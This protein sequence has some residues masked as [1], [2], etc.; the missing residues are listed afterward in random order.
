METTRA[1]I[2]L[3]AIEITFKIDAEDSGGSHTVFECRVAPAGKVP[4]PHSHDGFEETIYGLDGTST[5]TVD[6]ETHE[7]GARD[8]ICIKRGSVHGFENHGDEPTRF[9]AVA[10]PGVFGP[11]YFED[12]AGVIAAGHGGPP[13]VGALVAVMRRHG[14]T[15]AQP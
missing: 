14:L 6:G 8:C 3:G 12:L 5:W 15:P 1:P 11:S 2:S 9:L 13:D 7:V 4:V 10:T